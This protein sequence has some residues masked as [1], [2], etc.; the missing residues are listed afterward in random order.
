MSRALF[1][2]FR[3]PLPLFCFACRFPG[4]MVEDSATNHDPQM[5]ARDEASR[6]EPATFTRGN[7][8][9]TAAV[10]KPCHH[11]GCIAPPQCC[12]SILNSLQP[13]VFP[14]A[15]LTVVLIW[16]LFTS[17]TSLG[18]QFGTTNAAA[19][20][21]TPFAG[22]QSAGSA[23]GI[24]TN[25]RF[26]HPVGVAVTANGTVYVTDRDNETIREITPSGM[27]TT[28]AGSPGQDGYADGIGAAA[29]F[30]YLNGVAL[31]ASVFGDIL[32]L[33]FDI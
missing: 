22:R 8:R 16:V 25:A 20:T 1:L 5:R 21:W 19:Y 32:V 4:E 30:S 29:R 27:V 7:V 10:A 26:F 9:W 6:L 15:R 11:G 24:G 14:P 33:D 3:A 31:D 18:Q 2:H 13:R 12:H 17:L 28:I 23:D